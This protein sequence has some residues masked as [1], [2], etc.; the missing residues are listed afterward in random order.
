M[1][2]VEACYHFAGIAGAD[3]H[4]LTLRQLWRMAVGRIHQTRQEMFEQSILIWG[5]DGVD[6][7]RYLQF[8]D[9]Y[10]TGKGG[11]VKMDAKLAAAVEAEKER[12]RRENPDLPKVQLG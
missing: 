2:A 3:P 9:L 10:Q 1:K 7:E 12:I 6:A 8:G 4:R 5:L 11:P